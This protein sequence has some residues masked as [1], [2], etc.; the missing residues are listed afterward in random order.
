M[1]YLKRLL[2]RFALK[3][4][5]NATQQCDILFTEH[6]KSAILKEAKLF[7][8]GLL[9]QYIS[10]KLRQDANKNFYKAN[11]NYDIIFPQAQIYTMNLIKDIVTELAV[12]PR[13]PKGVNYRT[14]HKPPL[15]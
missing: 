12:D 11:T 15:Q 10:Q 7:H 3:H 8:E 13:A 2:L 6:E 5:W 1:K 9:L 14:A 4:I